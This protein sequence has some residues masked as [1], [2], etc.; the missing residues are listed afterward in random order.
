MADILRKHPNLRIEVAGHTDNAGS[1]QHNM[2]L[3]RQ[4][5]EA[6]RLYLVSQGVDA[7][8]ILAKGYGPANPVTSNAT[9]EGRAENRR[10][11]LRIIG[12]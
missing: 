9:A 12:N 1:A 7:G 5:A 10:V 8:R 11:E 6:V 4:R 2:R 3:S